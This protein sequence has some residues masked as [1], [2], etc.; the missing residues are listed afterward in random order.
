MLA[1]TNTK[2]VFNL[3]LDY[4]KVRILLQGNMSIK[5]IFHSAFQPAWIRWTRRR[6]KPSALWWTGS[7]CRPLSAWGTRTFCWRSGWGS[8]QSGSSERGWGWCVRWGRCRRGTRTLAAPALKSM[9]LLVFKSVYSAN[10]HVC[11]RSVFFWMK[12]VFQCKI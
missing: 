4:E 2:P 11:Q 12:K 3:T 6:S 7:A 1:D 10:Y 9:S 8:S 5:Q